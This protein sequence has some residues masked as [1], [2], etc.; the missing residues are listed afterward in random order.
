VYVPGMDRVAVIPEREGAE[1]DMMLLLE[2]DVELID[3]GVAEGD[4]VVETWIASEDPGAVFED[5]LRADLPSPV[6]VT[7]PWAN[8]PATTQAE[9][10]TL[11]YFIPRTQQQ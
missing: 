11:L 1:V 9:K 6:M 10:R 7:P 2:G 3:V 4:A 5:D 8:T